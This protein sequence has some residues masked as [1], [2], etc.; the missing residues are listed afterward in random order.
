M[1]LS[2]VC[3]DRA[4]LYLYGRR[5]SGRDLTL[6]RTYSVLSTNLLSK[7]SSMA[8]GARRRQSTCALH[9]AHCRA[10]HVLDACSMATSSMESRN[11]GL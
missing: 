11:M 8:A 1:I 4:F 10:H 2:W 3:F 7:K 6:T 9:S 5:I